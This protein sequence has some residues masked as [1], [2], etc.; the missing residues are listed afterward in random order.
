MY[1]FTKKSVK[2]NARRR[3]NQSKHLS[4]LESVT[5]GTQRGSRAQKLTAG[6]TCHEPS[7]TLNVVQA[8]Q[9]RKDSF[10]EGVLLGLGSAGLELGDPERLLATGG[11]GVLYVL[12]EVGDVGGGIVPVDADEV[13]LAVGAGREEG[14]EPGETHGRA[15]VG[16]GGGTELGFAGEGHHVGLEAGGGVTGRKV[17]LGGEIG[18]VEGHEV[19]GAGGDSAGGGGGPWAGE[20]AGHA[21]EERDIFNA[22]DTETRRAGGPVVCPGYLG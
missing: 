5:K 1:A 13:D 2:V 12:L 15:T 11:V 6:I 20:G 18:L 3:S 16:N 8:I 22:G 10:Q 4:S 7:V 19:L 9:P 17:G 21:P 14:L